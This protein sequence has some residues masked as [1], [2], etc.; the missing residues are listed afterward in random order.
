MS[1]DFD[2]RLRAVLPDVAQRFGTPF[3]LYDAAGIDA[4]GTTFTSAFAGIDCREYFAVKAL[5]NPHVLRRL[6]AHGFGFDCSSLPEIEL[7]RAAGAGPGDLFFTSNNTTTAEL[8]AALAAGAFVTVDDEVVLDRLIEADAVP[9][10]LGLRINPGQLAPDFDSKLFGHPHTAKFGIPVDR[11]AA[12]CAKAARHG[13][14]SVGLHM[15]IAANF[16]TA[17]PTLFALDLLAEQGQRLGVEVALLNVGG[18]FGIPYRPGEEHLDLP[19]LAT[20]IR[21]RV[22][23][24]PAGFRPRICFENGRYLTGPHGVLVTRVINRMS[25]WREVVGV[26]TTVNALLRSV[27]YDGVYHHVTA[28]F[29][30]PRRTETVDVVGSLCTNIDRLAV[31]REIPA[32]TE[33]DLLIVHD[34]GA[35]VHAMA[36][37]YNGRLRP[38]ELLL[39]ADG[40]V[41]LIRRA[42]TEDDYFATLRFE[43]EIL[44][45]L[46]S[47]DS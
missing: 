40:S 20:A 38:K 17:E 11:L 14:R 33:G 25:K 13:V 30:D 28:P 8:L 42:E 7:A 41:E 12:V 21:E 32:V 2:Q 23:G 24:W 16:R 22:A 37:V 45:A 19:A 29:A 26:D 5:P 10:S 6:R 46:I 34:T 15:M 35:H 36:S 9:S 44:P 47:A 39:H 18:G 31:Q 43:P 4:T 3:Y 1:D 27:V